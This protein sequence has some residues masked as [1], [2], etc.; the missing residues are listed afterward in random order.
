[1]GIILATGASMG[2]KAIFNKQDD[3]SFDPKALLLLILLVLAS[4]GH[5][6]QQKKELS[7]IALI[8][9]SALLGILFY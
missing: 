1:M 8:L 5:K 2:F 7:P 3:I 6:H 4:W 9:F